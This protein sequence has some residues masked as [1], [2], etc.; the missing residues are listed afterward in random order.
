MRHD[1]RVQQ[2]VWPLSHMTDH[3]FQDAALDVRVQGLPPE[4]TT[5]YATQKRRE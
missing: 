4:M 1:A 2:E 5:A 3:R